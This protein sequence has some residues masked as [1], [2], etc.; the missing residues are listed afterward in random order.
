L[1][2]TRPDE[3]AIGE[4]RMVHPYRRLDNHLPIYPAAKPQPLDLPETWSVRQLRRP[5]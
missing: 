2:Y 4:V 1:N 3:N 5:T